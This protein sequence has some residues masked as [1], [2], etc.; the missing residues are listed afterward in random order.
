MQWIRFVLPALAATLTVPG[1]GADPAA[2]FEIAHRGASGYLPEHTL[3]A[4]AMAHGLGAAWIEQDVVM[5]RDGALVVLHDLT[6]DA[7]TDVA[8]RFPGRK[9]EDGKWYALDFTLAELKTLEVKERFDPKTGKPTHPRRYS[10]ELPVFRIAT[11]EES[12]SLVQSL[13]ASTGRQA[14]VYPEV[15]RP[16]WH[17]AQ[18]RDLGAAVVAML[19]RFGYGEKTDL[20]HLQCFEYDEIRRLREKIGYQG[21]LVQLLGGGDK[22]G[23]GNTDFARLR[24][25]EGLKELARWVDGIGPPLDEIVKGETPREKRITALVADA[26]EAGLVVHPY[27]ARSDSLPKWAASYRELTDILEEAGVEGYFTDFPGLRDG[28]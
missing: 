24:S 16:A 13:N 3:E 20:C 9:R 10:G 17:L 18:G 19:K 14:G 4:V 7:T 26:R 25:P 2:P 21:R 6:L 27:T 15:K 12:L 23:E 1:V 8:A 11:F 5:S 22:V 28:R